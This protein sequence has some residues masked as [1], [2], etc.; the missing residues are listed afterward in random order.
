MLLRSAHVAASS[1]PRHSHPVPVGLAPEQ[2]LL[3]TQ[4]ASLREVMQGLGGNPQI[5]IQ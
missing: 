1:G 3:D 4:A 2:H 5:L